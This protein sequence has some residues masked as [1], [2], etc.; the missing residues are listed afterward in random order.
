M[1]ISILY[2][3]M[4]ILRLRLQNYKS[5]RDSGWLEF[6]PGFTVV[7]GQN[8]SGKSALLEAFRLHRNPHHKHKMVGVDAGVPLDETSSAEFDLSI[9]GEELRNAILAN[10]GVVHV[11]ALPVNSEQD[12]TKFAL[13][14]LQKEQIT[15]QLKVPFSSGWLGRDYPSHALFDKGQFER[16]L[17]VIG[18]R[19]RRSVEPVGLSSGQMDSLPQIAQRE[20]DSTIYV[21]RAERLAIG[22]TPA[23][24]ATILSP[25]GQ[26]LAA[27]LHTWQGSHRGQFEEFNRH[28]AE[29]FPSIRYVSV[30]LVH[31]QSEVKVSQFDASIQ[32]GDLA[33]PLQNCGTGVGQVLCI[34]YV[35]MTV[36]RGVIVID[37][38]S[39][40]LHPGA[41]K[42][43]MQVLQQYNHQYIIGTHSAELLAT[44]KPQIIYSVEW[45]H[46]ESSVR[47][48]EA[49][50]VNDLKMLLTDLGVSFS[51]VFGYDRAV[52]VE[53][54]TEEICFPLILE[55]ILKE[56]ELGLVF[57]AMKNTG[58]FERKNKRQAALIWSIYKKV[59][60]GAALLPA[61]VSFSFD[62]ESRTQQEIDDLVRE[63]KGAAHFLPR[64]C[65]ENY[66]L[67]PEAIA[68]LLRWIARDKSAPVAPS[69]IE[70]AMRRA[71][72]TPGWSG[73]LADVNWLSNVHAPNL[74]KAVIDELGE[75][76][77][78]YDKVRHS[79]FL[80]EWLIEHKPQLLRELAAYIHSVVE[81]TRRPAT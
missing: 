29:I 14:V 80:T 15:L 70:E 20:C 68:A 79:K 5:F 76:G 7:I 16:S 40:F 67:E 27:V 8:N 71:G 54:P 41:A 77:N 19:A 21:F 59:S 53:G 81:T 61:T 11:P 28:V 51:D 73:D 37:E 60:S 64:L 45:K 74:L 49:D 55:K 58:D 13:S 56:V 4:K 32:R 25:D 65:Y 30:G 10:G 72:A 62:R 22:T 35:A 1:N 33:D 48:V 26:N 39:S 57:V 63:S 23:Q 66:L 17:G 69:R 43:L 50:Q 78:A 47:R 24:E 44:V 2:I 38:P 46:G 3:A 52:W 6:A 34:L 75:P 42:K 31:N 12:A 18:N 36:R 9:S